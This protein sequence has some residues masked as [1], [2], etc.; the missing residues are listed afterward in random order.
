MIFYSVWNGQEHL[1][2]NTKAAAINC[3][4]TLH[5]KWNLCPPLPFFKTN[6]YVER[7]DIG[8]ITRGKIL[9]ILRQNAWVTERV[10]I[11]SNK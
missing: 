7:I 9:R 5:N 2:F 11:W 4:K 6:I 3:A 10:K 8:K 1:Y